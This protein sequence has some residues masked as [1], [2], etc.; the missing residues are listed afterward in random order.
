MLNINR[1]VNKKSRASQMET[2]RERGVWSV[3]VVWG[4]ATL[5]GDGDRS[6]TSHTNWSQLT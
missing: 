1:S 6:D 3:C 2:E 5:G 4:R